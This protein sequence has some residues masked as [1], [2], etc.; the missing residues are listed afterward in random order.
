MD[1][2]LASF[3]EEGLAIHIATRSASLAPGGARVPAVKVDEDGEHLV[4]FV[5]KVSAAPILRDVEDNGQVALVFTRPV[6]E[7]GC[8]VKG[9]A[10]GVREAREDEREWV[11]AQWERFRDTLEVVGFPRIATDA[12]IVWPA[13]AVRVRIT[14]TFDQ[15]PGPGA[16]RP[17][18]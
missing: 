13:V 7:R 12:W 10:A 11:I 6:D 1:K 17:L 4:A 8:Q 15:T 14:A 2:Q 5:P 18:P 3:L 16:G 9:V